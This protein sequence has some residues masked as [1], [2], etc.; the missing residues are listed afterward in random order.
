MKE[1]AVTRIHKFGNIARV[2]ATILAV[3]CTIG[4]VLALAAGIGTCF[5][6]KDTF[7]VNVDTDV[8][9][10]ITSELFRDIPEAVQ[11]DS[12]SLSLNGGAVLRATPSIQGDTITVPFHGQ[13]TPNV[14]AI[15]VIAFMLCIAIATITIPMY[16]G[17]SLGKALQS[18]E[19]PF[20]ALVI[21]RIK[22]LA[23]CMIPIVFTDGLIDAVSGF[24]FGAGSITLSVN[25]GALFTVLI[26]LALAYIFQYGA[27]LQQ[28][29]DETL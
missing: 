5:I 14:S 16:A 8:S 19:S 1:Q 25:I 22:I 2:I 17:V 7:R 4:C 13:F 24:L 23:Y 3:L 6:P 15:T 27:M 29:S 18:C 12:A 21:R 26:I 11:L 9:V 10:K 20:D 28:E